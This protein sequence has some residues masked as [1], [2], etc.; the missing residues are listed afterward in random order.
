MVAVEA[1]A[2]GI[3]PVASVTAIPRACDAGIDGA[4]FD[5]EDPAA[6]AAVLADVDERPARFAELGRR[7]RETYER[8]FGVSAT[9][10]RSCWGST[11]SRSRTPSARR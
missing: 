9:T 8:G 6:L 10:S 1:M 3:A 2:A 5:A 11:A 4:L 7:A